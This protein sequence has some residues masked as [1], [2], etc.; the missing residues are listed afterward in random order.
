MRVLYFGAY[1][2]AYPR[3]RLFLKGL[4]QN[5]VKV[6]ECQ[7]RLKG[8]L[9]YI[10][11]GWKHFWLRRKYDALVVGFPGQNAV[12]LA[13]KL[14]D[15]PVIFDA[16]LSL[17]EAE[18]LDRQNLSPQSSRA[19]RLFRQER[20]AC[21]LADL[22]LVD[23][24]A[25]LEYFVEKYQLPR[26]K[27][28][29]IFVGTDE[30][31]FWPRP[32]ASSEF[33]VHFHGKYIPLQG[34]SY[35]V[36]AAR[37]LRD[38]PLTF[39]LLGR[40]QEYGRASALI[41]KYDLQNIRQIGMV[42]YEELP[43][44]IN[45]S[46]ICLGIFSHSPKTLRVIPNKVAE[47]LACGKAVITADSPAAR[48]LLTDGENIR[49]CRPGDPADLAAKILELYENRELR[50]RLGQNGRKLFLDKLTL[51]IL[52]RQLKILLDELV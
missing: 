49:L 44:F 40:G 2:P 41:Q 50:E 52:G 36:E 51:G 42:A 17:H 38:R 43:R 25:N 23:T 46:D 22:V 10:A 29:Q 24:K 39:R 34:A 45:D 21:A 3:N 5:G 1:N 19:Q 26:Q 27:F 16:F 7:S 20:Q 4:R 11:L 6:M 30:E 33:I 35:I 8:I 14:T 32:K 47:Y 15:K 18:V 37:L 31:I 9:K 13:K 48:E 12:K 28:R